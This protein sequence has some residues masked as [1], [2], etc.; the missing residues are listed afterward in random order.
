MPDITRGK[1]SIHAPLTGS[2]GT[3]FPV[4]LP[5]S[6]FQSTLP[7]R[8]ATGL[9]LLPRPVASISIHAPLTGSDTVSKWAV[10]ECEI[11]IHAPLTGSDQDTNGNKQ[12]QK[13]FNPRSPYGE[14]RLECFMTIV[15]L[16]FQST[17]PLRGA[18][19]HVISRVGGVDDF[20]PRSPYGE[21]P[22]VIAIISAPV[23]FQSTLPLRGATTPGI[24]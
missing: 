24:I 16:R 1:I 4:R 7:L 13:N 5:T 14:R 15:I 8:G 23:L 21:R 12:A 20:N 17:L 10:E 19:V 22:V 3:G 11:S 2:D 9:P 6:E 18:T